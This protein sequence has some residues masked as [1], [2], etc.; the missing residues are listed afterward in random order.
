MSIRSTLI[1]QDKHLIYLF[2]I[3]NYISLAVVWFAVVFCFA[4]FYNA[5]DK[6]NK[7]HESIGWRYYFIRFLQIHINFT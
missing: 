5:F 1:Q 2:P 3:L 4:L 6:A 7:S